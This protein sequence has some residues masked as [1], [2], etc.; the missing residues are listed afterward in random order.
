MDS[1]PP[2]CLFLG[3]GGGGGGVAWVQGYYTMQSHDNA[4]MRESVKYVVYICSGISGSGSKVNSRAMWP[5]D[6][7][8]G[9]FLP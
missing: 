8:S 6:S 1:R 2:V 5:L 7:I 9:Y 4:T 3:G